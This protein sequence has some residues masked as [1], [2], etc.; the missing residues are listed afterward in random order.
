MTDIIDGRPRRLSERRLAAAQW[1]K[2][3]IGARTFR[4]DGGQAWPHTLRSEQNS[5]EGERKTSYSS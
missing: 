4:L 3:D 1:R 5:P 2:V